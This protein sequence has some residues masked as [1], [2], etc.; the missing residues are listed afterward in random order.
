MKDNPELAAKLVF[1]LFADDVT[2]LATHQKREEAVKA[3]QWTVN[4]VNEWSAA[5]KLN[6][7][8]SKSEVG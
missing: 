8:G 2:I 1:S 3:A 4:L 6:L 5:W 7:N